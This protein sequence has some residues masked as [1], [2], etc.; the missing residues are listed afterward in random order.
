MTSGEASPEKL[1]ADGEPELAPLLPPWIAFPAAV[2]LLAGAGY[3]AEIG[4]TFRA[5]LVELA[6]PAPVWIE[7]KLELPAALTLLGLGAL[8]L[9]ARG[10]AYR[11]GAR[12][13]AVLAAATAALMGGVIVFA[14]AGALSEVHGRLLIREPREALDA[15]DF[16]LARPAPAIAPGDPV[17]RV[18]S[19]LGTPEVE[20]LRELWYLR[21]GV[22]VRLDEAGARVR[23]VELF[24]EPVAV[25]HAGKPRLFAGSPWHLG[26]VR[27]GMSAEEV[28]ALLGPAPGEVLE[29][30]GGPR[31]LQYPGPGLH[32][33][34][35]RRTGRVVALRRCAP[36]QSGA[37][38]GR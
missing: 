37:A 24:G 28:E 22:R 6:L 19:E 36:Q 13:G 20:R 10:G 27:V 31:W 17:D 5:A 29:A 35:D 4:P 16:P 38:D 25:G 9:G 32:V 26:P 33:A 21:E 3:L 15:A 34:L 8:A 30:R 12:A 7:L 23:Q 18:R 14:S 2:I 1:R 11:P